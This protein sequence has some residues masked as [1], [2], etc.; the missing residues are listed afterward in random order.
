MLTRDKQV[1]K[2]RGRPNGVK[3]KKKHKD[4]HNAYV[5]EPDGTLT[6]SQ[7]ANIRPIGYMPATNL[8]R[9]GNDSGF[10]Q[11]TRGAYAND[12]PTGTTMTDKGLDDANVAVH[13]GEASQYP[14]PRPSYN[15]YSYGNGPASN[16]FPPSEPNHSFGNRT[17]T[18]GNNSS[19]N[20]L[21]TALPPTAYTSP[22]Y[23]TGPPGPYMTPMRN[24][25]LPA[26]TT[27]HGYDS[28][29]SLSGADYYNTAQP[30]YNMPIDPDMLE[31]AAQNVLSYPPAPVVNHSDYDQSLRES[32]KRRR[33]AGG[34]Q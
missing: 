11:T 20:F 31:M 32:V 18:F 22:Y 33:L 12:A 7:P 13:P 19:S 6:W 16:S 27:A 8:E 5:T 1:S 14:A 25:N 29:V 2:K 24:T 10:D 28:S 34:F 30:Q 3:N 9:E 17:F 21:P 15:V 26:V 4:A 23:R